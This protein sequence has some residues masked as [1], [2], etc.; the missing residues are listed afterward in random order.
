M[1]RTNLIAASCLVALLTGCSHQ[2]NVRMYVAG[3]SDLCQFGC[4]TALDHALITAVDSRDPAL[5][6]KLDAVA[7]RV[8]RR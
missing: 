3:H 4:Q 8:L 1:Q 2:E 5:L 6:A 7:G